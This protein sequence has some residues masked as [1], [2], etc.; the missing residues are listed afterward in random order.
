[1]LSPELADPSAFVG[2]T[3]TLGDSAWSVLLKHNGLHIEILIDPSS[4]SVHRQGRR[5]GRRAGIR[6]HHDHGL[7]GFGGRRRRRGQG[8]RL[9]QLAGPERG[10][11]VEEVAKGG[12]SFT[13]VLN[14]DRTF[15]RPHP[16]PDG[17][18]ELTLPG[19]SL[20]FVRNVVT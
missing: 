10:D 17:S 3:G 12:K 6:D 20:L 2:Y 1:V 5:Q 8:A 9:P 13:R 7:R 19:R 14:P 18:E 15:T 11:L 16:T 4:P